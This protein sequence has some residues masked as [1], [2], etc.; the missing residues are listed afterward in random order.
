[1]GRAL[2]KTL[3]LTRNTT[4][5][6]WLWGSTSS[7][8][9]VHDGVLQWSV[10]CPVLLSLYTSLICDTIHQR[11]H[12]GAYACRSHVVVRLFS[13]DHGQRGWL[14]TIYNS[15]MRRQTPCSSH[16]Y[17]CNLQWIYPPLRLEMLSSN[18]DMLHGAYRRMSDEAA[19]MEDHT[20]S[21][22]RKCY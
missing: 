18:Q 2:F 9:L 1:M 6:S 8:K 11:K 13:G 12:P 22:C 15:T 20:K 17:M 19:T 10:L 14:L 3:Q 21:V 5:F 4:L 16:L 7:P